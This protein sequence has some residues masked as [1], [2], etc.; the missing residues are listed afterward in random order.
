[1]WA[2]SRCRSQAVNRW[3]AKRR[4]TFSCPRLALT[5]ACKTRTLPFIR[6][7]PTGSNRRRIKCGRRGEAM[8][9]Q[10]RACAVQTAVI[11]TFRTLRHRWVVLVALAWLFGANVGIAR[12]Q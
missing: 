4:E 3:V 5:Q 12:G 9:N 7:R 10:D 1:M 6:L 2:A 8:L 11:Y